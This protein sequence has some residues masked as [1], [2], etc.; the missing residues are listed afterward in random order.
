MWSLVSVRGEKN[1]TI[2]Q[3]TGTPQS[4]TIMEPVISHDS[5][6]AGKSR[7]ICLLGIVNAT[8]N[9]LDGITTLEMII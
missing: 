3:P 5:H 1:C 6:K 8:L 9:S 7:T 2:L 4:T